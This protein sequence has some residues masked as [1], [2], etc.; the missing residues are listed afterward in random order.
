M[1]VTLEVFHEDML[2]LKSEA[3]R[4][5]PDMSVTDEV[6][7]FDMSPL[8]AE[9]PRNIDF[10]VVTS[11]RSGVSVASYVIFEAS[12]NAPSIEDHSVSPHRSIE[13]SF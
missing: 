6:F 13:I 5:M 4:N 7:Q 9:A 2:W 12:W 8:K 11:D 1:S 10:R 3:P